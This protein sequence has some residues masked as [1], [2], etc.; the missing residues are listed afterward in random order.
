MLTPELVEALQRPINEAS[1]CGDDLEYDPAFTALASLAQGK[2][3]QQFGDTVI[4]AVEPDWRQVAEQAD[5]VLRRSKDLRAA[6]L[7]LRAATRLD[8]MPGFAS[9]L[10]LLTGLLDTYWDGI[11]PKLDADD[12][13]DPTMRLNALMPLTDDAMVL[14]DLYD[15]RVGV[16]RGVG[17]IRVRDIAIAH[18]LIGAAGG[19]PTYSTAQIQGALEEIHT[20]HPAALQSLLEVRATIAALHELL[21]VRTGRHDAVDMDGLRSLG[22]LLHK[23]AASA[24]G[25]PVQAEADVAPATEAETAASGTAA[26]PAVARGEITTRQDALHM[27]DRVISYLIQAE[28]G[29][30]APLLIERAKKLIGVD[31]F[32]IMANLAPNAMDTIETVTGKRPSSD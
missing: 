30:P 13:N 6:M 29:N 24:V 7:L 25:S 31:F 9:G 23:V 21:G 27:L 32:E 11:H 4:P 16:A 10:G 12:D 17:A 5:A 15:A 3:E 1:P 28:P 18:N 22:N 26:S 14:R 2:A 20:E 19:E 8:G